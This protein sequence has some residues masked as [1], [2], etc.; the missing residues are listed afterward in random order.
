MPGEGEPTTVLSLYFSR[1]RMDLRDIAVVS[2]ILDA[3]INGIV[4]HLARQG[5]R[6]DVTVA[7]EERRVSLE[8]VSL[9]HSSF[10]SKLRPVWSDR[11]RELRDD[12]G[13]AVA[14]NLISAAV[15]WIGATL[16]A[17]VLPPPGERVPPV[18]AVVAEIPPNLK[19]LLESLPRNLDGDWTL[20]LE[21]TQP[22]QPRY[23]IRVT[24]M[25]TR[26]FLKAV[27]A[28]GVNDPDVDLVLGSLQNSPDD[29]QRALASGAN[30]NITLG[31]LIR[32]YQ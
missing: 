9:A 3:S 24:N 27:R 32:R 11:A 23:T 28:K 29:V 25:S 17:A 30:I 16:G 1:E 20:E 31:E 19:S 14:A 21:V 26:S 6:E 4:N 22:G 15:L 7:V 12:V 18:P 8:I 2:S 5:A 10:L 13:T